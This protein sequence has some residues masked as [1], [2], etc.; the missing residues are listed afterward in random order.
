[1]SCFLAYIFNFFSQKLLDIYFAVDHQRLT[2]F[3]FHSYISEIDL[4]HFCSNRS[5]DWTSMLV[6]HLTHRMCVWTRLVLSDDKKYIAAGFKRL[7][8]SCDCPGFR[9]FQHASKRQ[10]HLHSSEAL[11]MRYRVHH[12]NVQT[13]LL[14]GLC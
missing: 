3:F 13:S 6:N 2:F 10:H 4:Y 11:G 9:Y 7:S 1:M 8:L 14:W 12:A 5:I